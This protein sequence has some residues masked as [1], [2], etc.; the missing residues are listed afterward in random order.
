[1]ANRPSPLTQK[2]QVQSVLETGGRI[3]QLDRPGLLQLQDAAGAPIPAWQ[4]AL[5]AALN[6]RQEVAL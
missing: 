2:A 6:D 4:N 1:M 5:R 3:V